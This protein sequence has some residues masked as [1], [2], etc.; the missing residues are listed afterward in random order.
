MAAIR[1]FSGAERRRTGEDNTQVD[2]VEAFGG[3]KVFGFLAGG[4]A[5][6]ISPRKKVVWVDQGL[7]TRAPSTVQKEDGSPYDY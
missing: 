1:V 2:T 5:I 4:V 7:E 3:L 6:Y